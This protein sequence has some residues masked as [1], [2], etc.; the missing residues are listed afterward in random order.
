MRLLISTSKTAT[1]SVQL[2]SE[3][4]KAKGKHKT[5]RQAFFSRL[6]T[7]LAGDRGNHVSDLFVGQDTEAFKDEMYKIVNEIAGDAGKSKPKVD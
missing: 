6:M 5:N 2:K 1:Q 3:S 7:K 4:K